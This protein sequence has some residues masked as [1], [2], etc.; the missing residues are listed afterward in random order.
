VVPPSA[1][2]AKPSPSLIIN[3]SEDSNDRASPILSVSK[4]AKK[5]VQLSMY[6]F[7]EVMELSA[8]LKKKKL[9]V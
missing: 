5:P 7:T 9:P 2:R 3:S 1:K 8:Y 6:A 4:R